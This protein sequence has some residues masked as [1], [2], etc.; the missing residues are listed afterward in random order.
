MPAII[1][2]LRSGSKSVFSPQLLLETGAVAKSSS[3][4]VFVTAEPAATS[5]SRSPTCRKEKQKPSYV[6]GVPA[7]RIPAGTPRGVANESV[8]KGS[9]GQNVEVP[10]HSFITLDRG[11]IL[12]SGLLQVSNPLTQLDS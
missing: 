9:K 12:H 1:S 4:F 7:L 8:A 3:G 10:S 5:K 2:P 11:K 6:L